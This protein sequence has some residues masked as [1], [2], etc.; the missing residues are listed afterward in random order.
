[1]ATEP[2]GIDGGAPS[3]PANGDRTLMDL[4]EEEMADGAL[5]DL[6]QMG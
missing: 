5:L 4:G 1:M 2:D 6:R 3:Y